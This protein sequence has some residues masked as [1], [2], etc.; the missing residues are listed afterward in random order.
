MRH[1]GHGSFCL[2]RCASLCFRLFWRGQRFCVTSE[3]RAQ[4][5]GTEVWQGRD[6]QSNEK[7]AVKFEDCC[8]VLR[9]A[10]V[11]TELLRGLFGPCIAARARAS[12][13]EAPWSGKS[14][15]PPGS[16]WL[17]LDSAWMRHLLL[18]PGLWL[19]HG[20]L[21]ALRSFSGVARRWLPPGIFF[22]SF[23]SICCFFCSASN[24][25]C[26]WSWR[27][28]ASPS[29]CVALRRH[30]FVFFSKGRVRVDLVSQDRLQGLGG[31]GGGP[32]RFN[33]QLE[34]RLSCPDC[35]PEPNVP[36]TAVL[37]ADQVLRRIEYLHSKAA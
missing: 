37:V 7:V 11:H 14:S 4:R 3:E 31:Q 20:S 29:R 35:C 30:A 21:K 6:K 25:S 27:C 9:K 36:R 28:W 17:A 26:A 13:L 12:S 2:M 10:A 1:V 5:A 33:P 24:A 19:S 8:A 32:P 15:A 22:V 16:R 34:P 18:L 23:A